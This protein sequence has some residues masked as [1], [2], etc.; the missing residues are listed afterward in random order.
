MAY[1]RL[2]EDDL[3]EIVHHV[4]TSA[5][6]AHDEAENVDEDTSFARI[7]SAVR[8]NLDAR[9]VDHEPRAGCCARARGGL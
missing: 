1:Y 3:M 2:N 4:C 8:N 7:Y 9:L 5:G 6:L